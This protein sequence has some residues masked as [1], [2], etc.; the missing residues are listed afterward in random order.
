MLGVQPLVGRP[1][2]PGDDRPGCPARV[3]LS[4]AFWQRDLR[5]RSRRGRTDADAQ[6][7]H[8]EIVGVTPPEF[9]GLEV[10]RPFDVTLPVCADAMFSD[11]KQRTAG[12]RH[13]MVAGVF[14]RLKPGWTRE[15]ADRASRDHLS[16]ALSVDASGGLP[17]RRA[18]TKYL[19]F[20]LGAYPAGTGLSSLRE[21]Y[22]S[23]LWLLL[24][25]AGLVLVIACANLA[26]LLLA[27]ATARERE[28]AIRLGLGASRSRVVR[29]L[30]T[31]SL[32]LASMGTLA[33]VV[34]AGM[35][36]RALVAFLDAGL[37]MTL[38]W[39]VLAFAVALAVLTC[40][41]FGLAPALKGTRWARGR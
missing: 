27:R 10:G 12:G 13:G 1:L 19:N 33:G 3:L 15:R 14:G 34:L 7:P 8:R 4:Y 39:R 28:I 26:N 18:S 23:P 35:L 2:G 41:L 20:K 36:S 11:D 29:Q 40:A 25:L 31:E 38:D 9:F 5:R 32:L 24:G 16:G 37:E 22:E 6:R 21:D 30:L 17:A